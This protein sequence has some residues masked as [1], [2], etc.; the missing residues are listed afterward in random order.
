VRRKVIEFPL[1]I[2][3]EELGGGSKLFADYVSGEQTPVNSILGGFLRGDAGWKDKVAESQHGEDA[4]AKSWRSLVDRLIDYNRS[5]GVADDVVEKLLGARDGG[6]R[7]VVTGQQ[8]GALGGALL[9]L[10]KLATAVELAAY[11]EESFGTPCLALYWVGSDDVDFQE[12]R[13]LFLVDCDLNP[14]ATTIDHAA[15]AAAS[16]VGDISTE[17]DTRVWESVGP[18]VAGCPRGPAVSD[19]IR[20]ALAAAADHGTVTAR[21]IAAL[22]GGRA[23]LVDGREPAVRQHARSLFLE[24]FDRETDVRGAVT[25]GGR[26]LEDAGY[27]AQLWPGPDSG[28]FMVDDGKR[29]KIGEG[30]REAA[31]ARMEKDVTPFSPGVALR[32][33]VQDYVFR[34]VAVVLGPAE[35]AYRA[36][37]D[38][39][40]RMME[41]GRP[42]AFPRMQATYVSPAVVD[43]LR[44]TDQ[45]DVVQLLTDPSSFVKHLYASGRSSEIAASAAKIRQ[46]FDAEVDRFLSAA[47]ATLDKKTA[48]KTRK[49]LRDVA[50]RL[51]QAL[52]VADKA[53]KSAALSRWPFLAGLGEFIRPKAKPQD[54]YL[55][56]LAPFVFA[57]EDARTAITA[58]AA[59]FVE[60]ALDG[61]TAHVVYSTR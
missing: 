47:G 27:H 26:S 6:V 23:A 41:I 37:L 54:R 36:Q 13:E 5:L 42:I 1:Q 8:P 43:M 49:R 39:V 57:G 53:G 11:V 51:E 38:S 61:R 32:N 29:K 19:V 10:Y 3:V 55:S 21:I 31:R 20:R 25:E 48:E 33:L 34:P 14:F 44:A 2:P 60:G 28:V 30:G 17:A 40:Y 35:I 15:Y 45:P 24:Y 4:G 18:L 59:T 22:S 46:T 58:A 16:P 9:S 52:D 56:A 50:R 12:I 7:F